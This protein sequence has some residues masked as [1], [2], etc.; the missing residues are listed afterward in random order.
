[1]RLFTNTEVNRNG[2]AEPFKGPHLEGMYPRSASFP[3]FLLEALNL[4]RPL[5]L[6][7]PSAEIEATCTQAQ[8]H[9]NQE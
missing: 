8:A 5:T 2:L 6:F 1:M 9:T 3:L 7:F 4:L